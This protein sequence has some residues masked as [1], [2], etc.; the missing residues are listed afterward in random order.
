M[1]DIFAQTPQ[2]YRLLF[3]LW[4]K[5]NM[6]SHDFPH[7]L[8][9]IE[10][11]FVT[12]KPALL[13][14]GAPAKVAARQPV[15]PSD[16]DPIAPEMAFAITGHSPRRFYRRLVHLVDLLVR[17]AR[18]ILLECELDVDGPGDAQEAAEAA[19]TVL[20]GMWQTAEDRRSLVWALRDGLL[21]LVVEL[22]T[23][24]PTYGTRL[25]L[26]WISQQ[27]IYVKV[28]RALSPGGQPILFGN[29]EVDMTMQER[30]AILHSSP[31][32]RA[33]NALINAQRD[34]RGSKDW[35]THRAR[36]Q[37]IRAAI[38]KYVLQFY[39]SAELSPLDLRF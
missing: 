12:I 3:D 38:D 6:Y 1:F 8:E 33:A 19:F 34:G 32:R 7:A 29:S 9:R 27:A 14:R 25:L 11:L 35:P 26:D 2:I 39:S 31:S 28:L 18:G 22:N 13:G 15:Q 36:C 16:A 21:N 20:L 17:A 10:L 4:L 24:R 23:T 37:S 5:I 30:V